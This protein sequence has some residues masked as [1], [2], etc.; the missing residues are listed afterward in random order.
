MID[1][2][3]LREAGLLRKMGFDHVLL[4]TGESS[5]KV[6]LDYINQALRTL[7]PFFSNLSIE[8]QPMQQEDYESL[9]ANGLHAVLVYQET[10]N[11]ESYAKHHI[12]GKK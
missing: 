6:G 10:Y 12:K 3:I 1:A 11:R 7:R 8:V 5:K 9:K 4:V 2:E